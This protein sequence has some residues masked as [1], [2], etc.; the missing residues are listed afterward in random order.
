MKIDRW[1]RNALKGPEAEVRPR[2]A[3]S[4]HAQKHG[5]VPY[6]CRPDCRPSQ[7]AQAGGSCFQDYAFIE[8]KIAQ[9]M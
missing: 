8:S 9:A 7:D 4:E 2:R 3:L 6:V 5:L 1:W